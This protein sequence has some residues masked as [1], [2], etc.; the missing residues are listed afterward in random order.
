MLKCSLTGASTL[1]SIL[2]LSGEQTWTQA[3]PNAKTAGGGDI[4]R[5]RAGYKGQSASSATVCISLNTIESSVGVVRVIPNLTLLDWKPRRANHVLIC[6]NVL[7]AKEI[8]KPTLTIVHFGDITSIGNDISRNMLRS[9]KIGCNRFVLQWMIY[10]TNDCAKSQSFFTKRLQELCHHQ[11]YSWNSK[12]IWYHLNSRTALVWN[13][14]NPK[15]C[16]LW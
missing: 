15:L 16:K 13:M 4:R 12:S 3:S 1:A 9:V 8:I 11:Y 2:P 10:Q 5:F 7:T 14:Q 6:S